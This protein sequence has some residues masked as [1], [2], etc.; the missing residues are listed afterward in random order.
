MTK[1][2]WGAANEESDRMSERL[3][4]RRDGKCFAWRNQ[5]VVCEF[6]Q[7]PREL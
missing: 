5:R 3:G 7:F 4:G 6:L 2:A 1:N